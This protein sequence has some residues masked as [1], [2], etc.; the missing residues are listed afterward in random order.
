MLRAL[1]GANN[2][3]FLVGLGLDDAAQSVVGGFEHRLDRR[4][5][6]G[7]VLEDGSRAPHG[8]R[9]PP[10]LPHRVTQ[11]ERMPALGGY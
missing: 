6:G 1:V 8:R 11:P 2:D 5:L 10:F 4:A 7:D 3:G 9:R